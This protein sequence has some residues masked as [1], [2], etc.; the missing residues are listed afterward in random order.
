MSLRRG[1]RLANLWSTRA[2]RRWRHENGPWYLSR[3]ARTAWRGGT[4]SFQRDE[5]HAT[6]VDL[7]NLS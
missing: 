1:P 3:M 4:A 2:P 6:M 7:G 5:R